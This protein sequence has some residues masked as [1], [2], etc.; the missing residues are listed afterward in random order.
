MVYVDD[1]ES[2][3]SCFS[4]DHDGRTAHV[5]ALSVLHELV[6]K[7]AGG[8]DAAFTFIYECFKDYIMLVAGKNADKYC[9]AMDLVAEG[10]VGL[11][12]A[13][14]WSAEDREKDFIKTAIEMIKYTI[15][16]AVVQSH[17]RIP[18]EMYDLACAFLE[19]Y[20]R[21]ME[22]Y[23]HAPSL[24]EMH[25]SE[26][27]KL[28]EDLSPEDFDRLVTAMKS[29]YY[30]GRMTYGET[31]DSSPLP[32]PEMRLFDLNVDSDFTLIRDQLPDSKTLRE[33]LTQRENRIINMRFGL[34]GDAPKSAQEIGR[35]LGLTLFRVIYIEKKA[36][37]RLGFRDLDIFPDRPAETEQ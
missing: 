4:E 15:E 6:C 35:E 9:D 2:T 26:G 29:T 7:A 20:N 28:P 14:E 34:D 21:F 33:T 22:D 19:E 31:L 24:E 8:D 16:D 18:R 32:E 27:L 10:S 25:I 13:V 12:R 5:N 36:L 1:Y 11:L 30:L 23:G 37:E 3:F 17:P